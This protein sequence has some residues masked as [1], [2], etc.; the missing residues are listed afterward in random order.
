M[1]SISKF[2]VAA[3]AATSLASCS[4]DFGLGSNG[5]NGKPD[6]VATLVTGDDDKAFTRLG[7]KEDGADAYGGKKEIVW[8]TGDKIR[9]FT[10]DKLSQDIYQLSKGA[11]KTTGEFVRTQTTGLIGD[12][13]A[14]TEADMVYGISA[15]EI[16]VD[17]KTMIKPRLTLTIPREYTPGKNEDGYQ[18]FTIPFWG[19]AEV[20]EDAEN[21]TVSSYLRGLTAY[22]RVNVA[23]LPANTKYIV[24][25]THGGGIIDGVSED[26]PAGNR[27]MLDPKNSI[28][29]A[30]F[31]AIT[32]ANDELE[33]WYG[34]GALADSITGGYSEALSGTLNAILEGNPALA[35]D[36]R[37]VHNDELIVNLEDCEDGIFYIPIVVGQYTKLNVIAASYISDKYRYC[38][39]GTILKTFEDQY[40]KLNKMY[41]LNMNLIDFDVASLYDINAAIKAYNGVAGVTTLINVGNLVN[42]TD[43]DGTPN[44]HIYVQGKGNLKINIFNI[45]T[46]FAKGK[47]ATTPLLVSEAATWN[48][49]VA[50]EIVSGT[51]EKDAQGFMRSVELNVP[52]YWYT[53][54]TATATN[55][56]EGFVRFKLPTWNVNLGTVDGLKAPYISADILGPNTMLTEGRELQYY[57]EATDPTKFDKNDL[58]YEST[59]AIRI[60]NGFKNVN[61]LKGQTGDVFAHTGV[62]GDGETE[63]DSLDI[64]TTAGINIRLQDALVGALK[65]SDTNTLRQVFNLGSTAIKKIYNYQENLFEKKGPNNEIL[66]NPDVNGTVYAGD[67]TNTPRQVAIRA[68]WTGAALSPYA[69]ANGYDVPCVVTA[70]QL[71][72]VG[73]GLKTAAN[74]NHGVGETAIEPKVKNY[75]IPKALVRLVWLGDKIYPWIGAEAT[76]KYFSIDGEDV[77]LKN[78][79]FLQEWA[80]AN[81]AIRD[82]HWCCTSCWSPAVSTQTIKIGDNIGL[83]RSVINSDSVMITRINLNDVYFFDEKNTHN[84]VGAIVGKVDAKKVLFVDNLV[85]EDKI[86]MNGQNVGG[87]AG[88]V[89]ADEEFTAT[90][91]E[92]LGSSNVS[93]YIKS[94]LANVGGAIGYIY[95][96]SNKTLIEKNIVNMN[97]EISSEKENV[98][99]FAGYINAT[100]SGNPNISALENLIFADKIYG[101]EKVGGFA[102]YINATGSGSPNISALDNKITVTN[103]ITAT[104]ADCAG[105]FAGLVE[106]TGTKGNRFYRN[107]VT[108]KNIIA[109]ADYA[110]GMIGNA[111]G[112]K[113]NYGF[114]DDKVTIGDTELAEGAIT[115]GE[116][117]AAGLAGNIYTNARVRVQGC[118]VNVVEKINAA[119]K[120]AGGLFGQADVE[121]R[122]NTIALQSA[123]V[124][125]PII[126]A[127]NGLVGG[128]VGQ[129]ARG[130]TNIGVANP[131]D[132]FETNIQVSTYLSGKY[133]IGG[134]I[135]NNAA[136]NNA[137]VFINTSLNGNSGFPFFRPTV[138]SHVVVNIATYNQTKAY[139]D[140]DGN[141]ERNMFGTMS[142]VLGLMQDDL[143][144]NNS[145]ET[146]DNRTEEMWLDVTDN[147][148]GSLKGSLLFKYHG[149]QTHN[150]VDDAG[151]QRYWGDMNGYVGFR[152]SGTYTLSSQKNIKSRGETQDTVHPH[153]LYLTN[154]EKYDNTLSWLQRED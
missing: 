12:K 64:Q 23:E 14:I 80:G 146:A 105:G 97:I 52:A 8:A 134:L 103:N 63:I 16:D 29:V 102:G 136:S 120:Y 123:K 3:L 24:L 55:T 57:E 17:G 39:S 89:K 106:T 70:A 11:G 42:G 142:N 47:T 96:M 73:E 40:F 37:L 107:E 5:L 2:F 41:Y 148:T 67:N 27:Y 115:A 121:T 51:A 60:F 124:T 43:P 108:A 145:H 26:N 92:V 132:A 140:F 154:G 22:L 75:F 66:G 19:A 21:A 35:I 144:F 93:G 69:I 98:G 79:T 109:K 28:Q 119:D 20:T 81:S 101:T 150:T 76:V 65:F 74:S 87:M 85:G 83:I 7:A 18:K 90:G 4:D 113:N 44:D 38:Y 128:E 48:F 118:E 13:Y 54:P 147:M 62:Q 49:D 138:Y 100:G 152:D 126:E 111:I 86:S 141:T 94:K 77:E 50:D 25:T 10:L 131:D 1:R 68:Y 139:T 82:P 36:S 53:A 88:E 31:G 58:D 56:T 143:T 130:T 72:S 114:V 61:I 99:G 34:D 133:A 59:W 6:M 116:S 46:E 32:S 45:D 84:N 30:P 78:M 91:N 104:A 112:E 110:G 151:E 153:N 129:V 117:W 71:A 15:A 149:G 122:D 33:K 137:P 95:K 127:I 125:T 135:G 9:V